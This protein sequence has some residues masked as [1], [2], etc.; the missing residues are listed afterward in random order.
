M[1]HLQDDLRNSTIYLND[2][3]NEVSFWKVELSD[4]AICNHNKLL[5]DI[6]NIMVVMIGLNS[7]LYILNAENYKNIEEVIRQ[8]V[9]FDQYYDS[10]VSTFQKRLESSFEDF[11]VFR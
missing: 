1:C 2:T 5:D 9:G 4:S 10:L 6:R 3:K 8:K 11:F 7:Q